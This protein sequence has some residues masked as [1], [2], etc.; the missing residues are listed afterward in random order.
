M[1]IDG[2]ILGGAGLGVDSYI[3]T[4]IQIHREVDATSVVRFSIS[5]PF[6]SSNE[7]DGFGVCHT[8]K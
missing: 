6:G 2:H 4:T 5:I 7:D 8:G 1:L 3:S